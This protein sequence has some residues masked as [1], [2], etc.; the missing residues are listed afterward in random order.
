MSTKTSMTDRML[1]ALRLQEATYEEIEADKDATD[2]AAFVVVASAFV[3][4]A[5]HALM[6]HGEADTGIAAG[7]G[8]LVGWALSAWIA[9]F[10]GTRLLPGKKTKADWGEVARAV[11]YANTP[12][13][14]LIFIAIPGIGPIVQTLVGVWVLAAT[15][16]A[17]R[18]AFDIETGRAIAVALLSAFAQGVVVS[19]LLL[20]IASWG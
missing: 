8:A 20:W 5:G 1:G 4:A 10:V 16:V 14:F 18:A 3:A 7:V 17:M 19:V 13:F 11:A 9:L 2:E 12:R 6:E 15:V